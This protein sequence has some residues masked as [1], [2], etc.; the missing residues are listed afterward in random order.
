VAV[1][2]IFKPWLLETPRTEEELKNL[3]DH[4]LARAEEYKLP[5]TAFTCDTCE[6]RFICYLAFDLYNTD[7]DCLLMK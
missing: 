3:R 1:D 5:I 2:D 4:Q 7:D 6:T